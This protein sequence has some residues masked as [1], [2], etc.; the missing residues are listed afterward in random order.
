[1]KKRTH[2]IASLI[3]AASLSASLAAQMPMS[4]SAAAYLTYSNATATFTYSI[5]N[6][7]A[8]I[9]DV[10]PKNVKNGYGQISIDVPAKI[11]NY[12][13]VLG[14]YSFYRMNAPM[15]VD[16]MNVSE[17]KS[18]AFFNCN[19]LSEIILRQN[20]KKIA[21]NAFYNCDSLKRIMLQGS[22][23]AVNDGS[24]LTIES[25]AFNDCNN[26]DYLSFGCRDDIII[27][28]NAFY[29]STR[30]KSFDRTKASF[31]HTSMYVQAGAFNGTGIVNNPDALVSSSL[32]RSKIFWSNIGWSRKLEGKVLVVD[33]V[34]QTPDAP[35]YDETR[36]TNRTAHNCR[37]LEREAAKYGV[38]LNITNISAKVTTSKNS[39]EIDGRNTFLSEAEYDVLQGLKA[40]FSFL[41]NCYDIDTATNRLKM[42]YNVSEIAYVVDINKDKQCCAWPNTDREYCV[43][44]DRNSNGVNNGANHETVVMHELAHL[45]GA[46]DVYNNG[47][48]VNPS[49]TKTYMKNDMMHDNLENVGWYTACTLGWTDSAL[50]EDAVAVMGRNTLRTADITMRTPATFADNRK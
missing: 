20:C 3:T 18:K 16:C 33:L 9:S 29:G 38:N 37:L 45:F 44:Y 14:T 35:Y 10:S 13:V 25:Y 40:K 12:P 26:V 21:S 30:L 43:V 36:P 7:T 39:W 31:D 1:M 15:D 8:E 19:G 27:K 41:S 28:P 32:V 49:Y 46:P 47:I 24:S 11:N 5:K 23:Y 42:W 4:V 17:I 2:K 6:G 48:T 22:S 34:T 50:K